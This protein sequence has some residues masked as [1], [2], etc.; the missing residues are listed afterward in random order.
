MSPLRS[1]PRKARV[2]YRFCRLLCR[3]CLRSLFR[4]RTWNMDRVPQDLEGGMILA[5][6]H[7]SYF[8]PPLAA[9][10]FRRESR[11]IARSTLFSFGPFGRLIDSVGAI[12]IAR[13]ESDRA[14]LR[15]A[16]EAL[17]EGWFVTL[18]PEGTR[19]DT[20][21]IEQVKPGV[22]TLAVRAN[23]PVMPCFVHG[24]YDA[25]PRSCRIPRFGTR[26]DVFYGELIELPDGSLS[27][28]KRAQYVNDRLRDSL[29][30][31]ERA[32]HAKRPLSTRCAPPARPDSPPVGAGTDDPPL[33]A[34][35]EEGQ[36][37]ETGAPGKGSVEVAPG[38]GNNGKS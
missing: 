19:T 28:K 4:V 21:Y 13:G 23:V 35:T 10:M 38:V 22:G 25:W 8:D 14:A 5:S 20:G 34:E 15:L 3:W 36:S 9:C 33:R 30:E 37:E 16:D 26:I 24:A 1:N 12:P 2:W 29:L 7:Q 18:F 31:L 32:A 17:K 6:N 11:F 27:R